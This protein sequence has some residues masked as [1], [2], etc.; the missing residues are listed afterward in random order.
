MGNQEKLNQYEQHQVDNKL[1][2]YHL[3]KIDVTDVF[4]DF[5]HPAKKLIRRF[6]ER[7]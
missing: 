3:S 2:E 6:F 4:C 5:E 1:G 7:Y